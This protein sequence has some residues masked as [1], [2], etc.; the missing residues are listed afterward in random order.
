MKIVISGL[1]VMGGSLALAFKQNLSDVQ[2]YGYDK[3][4]VLREALAQNFIDEK[5]SAWPQECADAD[6]VFL[7]SP[8]NI[9]S[10]HLQDLNG[11]VSRQTVVTDVGSTKKELSLLASKINFSGTYAGGH[12]MT[13]AEKSGLKA[14]NPLL[15]ENAV[16]L[17]C[18]TELQENKIVKEKLLPVLDAVKAR[19]LVIDAEVHDEILAAISHLPQ[20]MA[21]ELINLAGGLN[22]E[23]KPYFAL[24]AGG[25]RD[26]TRIASSSI[27]IW[28]DIINSNTDNIKKVLKIYIRSLENAAT[29][30]DN[31]K[32]DFEAANEYRRQVPKTGKGFLSPLTDVMVFVTDQVGVV[33]KIASALTEKDIDIRDIELLKIREKEGGVFR[34]SFDSVKLANDAVKILENIGFQALLRE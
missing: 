2:I 14:A 10:R 4:E 29:R 15:F 12:P 21:V 8:L 3:P 1:G 32:P 30:L 27:D 28:Q 31:M 17:L 7:A 33:A 25:F 6:I 16:Y 5:I 26:L 13:G 20:I 34:L 23:E 11:V 24:A 22:S 19:V 9:L 18:G